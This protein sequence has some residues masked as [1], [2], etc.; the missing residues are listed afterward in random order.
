MSPALGWLTPM[1][2]PKSGRTRS[3]RRNITI[4]VTEIREG[5]IVYVIISGTDVGTLI[6]TCGQKL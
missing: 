3:L 4:I 5:K 1:F 6:S 2:E